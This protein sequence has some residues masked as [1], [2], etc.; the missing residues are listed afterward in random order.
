MSLK[1]QKIMDFNALLVPM[2]QKCD[3]IMDHRMKVK[4]TNGLGE[5]AKPLGIP[6]KGKLGGKDIWVILIG[7][8]QCDKSQ[9]VLFPYTRDPKLLEILLLKILVQ[10]NYFE[11]NY[12]TCE[13]TYTI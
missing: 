12:C 5:I 4:I 7:C 9:S 10:M 3:A 8:N 2:I 6:S 11:K 1:G 13:K